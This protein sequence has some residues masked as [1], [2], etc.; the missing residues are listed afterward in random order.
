MMLGL[1]RGVTRLEQH[2]PRWLDAGRDWF[3]AFPPVQVGDVCQHAGPISHGSGY[4][5]VPIWLS[6]GVNLLLSRFDPA[7]V[8]AAL[9]RD[10]T[11]PNLVPTMLSDLVHHPAA[12]GDYPALRRLLSGGA[13][14]IQAA[15]ARV[16]TTCRRDAN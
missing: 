13:P 11:L 14:M 16:A 12:P 10:T 2:D 6:G 9:R 5:F 4:F 3:Y 7:E 15:V 1:E 8:L